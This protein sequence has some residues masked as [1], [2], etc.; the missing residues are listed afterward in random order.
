MPRRR[1]PHPP[2]TPGRTAAAGW[3]AALAALALI[4]GCATLPTGGP[5]HLAR[6]APGRHGAGAPPLQLLPPAP[7]AGESPTQIVLGFLDASADPRGDYQVAREYLTRTAAAHWPASRAALVYDPTG[8][9]TTATAAGRAVSVSAPMVASL[10]GQ[11]VYHLAGSRQ[12]LQLTFHLAKTAAGWRLDAVP[13]PGVVLD[14][15]DFVATFHPLN[16]YFLSPDGRQ[17]VPDPREL[18]GP[19]TQQLTGLVQLLLAGPSGAFRGAVRS[20]FPR[21]TDLEAPVQV[22]GGT[23]YV[24]LSAAVGQGS[25][26]RRREMAAQ[27]AWTLRQ[28]GVPAVRFYAAGSEVSVPGVGSL[29]TVADY[30]GFA[31]NVLTGSLPLYGLQAGGLL[32]LGAGKPAPL[33]GTAGLTAAALSPNGSVLAGLRRRNGHAGSG[34]LALGHGRHRVQLVIG[35]PGTALTAVA[36]AAGFLPPSAPA[37]HTVWTVAD[38]DTDPVVVRAVTAP[39]PHGTVT[40]TAAPVAAP[41][42]RGRG[43]VSGFAV[44]RDGT[45]IA[46]IAGGTLYVGPVTLTR[47][48]PA[49]R[50]LAPVL[51]GGTVAAGPLAWQDADTLVAVVAPSGGPDEVVSVS[52]DGDAV[53]PV[54]G[55]GLPTVPTAL[56]AGPNQPLA[57]ASDGRV[58]VK[59]GSGWT[60]V[61][62]AWNPL[63][64]G[65]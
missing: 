6:A 63:Y 29:Q 2:R 17:L 64:P 35:G 60:G 50:S 58:W 22:S 36:A 49:L 30:A 18:P 61:S 14:A 48:V 45:R 38:P 8:L 27:L 53:S 57:A 65:S 3:A 26:T 55:A 62:D 24:Q 23:A 13:V 41:A 31:P 28:A 40:G 52:L 5:V 15:D 20:A 34:L 19:P 9:V 11:G 37:D 10:D 42:L 7:Q 59:Q 33:R 16:T 47:G 44:S 56:A 43:A 12:H 1:P 39:G 21:Q 32:R 4:S 51:A 25:A 46:V 54:T